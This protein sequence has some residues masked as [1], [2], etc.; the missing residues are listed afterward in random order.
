MND[1]MYIDTYKDHEIKELGP[2]EYRWAKPGT[3]IDSS[4]IIFRPGTVI[5]FGDNGEFIFRHS[6][7]D[8]V[9]WTMRAV[10]S[11][12]YLRQKLRTHEKKYDP[13]QTKKSVKE[14]IR[15]LL[16]TRKDEDH[17]WPWIELEERSKDIYD[18]FGWLD[19]DDEHQV[20]D[21]VNNHLNGDCEIVT[22]TWEANHSTIW[23]SW[24]LKTFCEK[25]KQIKESV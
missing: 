3:S 8:S 11:P 5:I 10:N 19:F 13:E 17:E 9:G 24:L 23:A 6:D 20:W 12:H 15:C 25:L 2:D 22:Y 16:M 7:T 21:F 1:E 14:S 4:T 18:D